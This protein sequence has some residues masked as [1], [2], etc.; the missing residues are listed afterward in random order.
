MQDIAESLAKSSC[1]I[2]QCLGVLQNVSEKL[3]VK[4]L[5]GIT[6][7]V[8]QANVLPSAPLPERTEFIENLDMQRKSPANTRWIERTELIDQLQNLSKQR[9]L[10]GTSSLE[11]SI[12][13]YGQIQQDPHPTK[14]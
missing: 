7:P 14:N 3:M 2:S 5:A 1:E 10:V 4:E 12:R 11:N 8:M 6:P 9:K 13:P